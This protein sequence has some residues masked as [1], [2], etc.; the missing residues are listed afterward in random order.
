MVTHVIIKLTT[1]LNVQTTNNLFNFWSNIFGPQ[2]D[3]DIP[4]HVFTGSEARYNSNATYFEK[5]NEVIAS[6]CVLTVPIKITGIGGLAEVATDPLFRRKGLASKL[7]SVALQD[8][9]SND[10]E[11]LF[12][13]TGNPEA[14][15]IYHQLGWRKIT[16]ANV[17]VNIT[18]NISPEEYLTDRFT[19]HDKL[20]VE[21]AT[22]IARIPMIPL[23]INPHDWHVLDVNCGMFSTKYGI[24]NSCMGLYRRYSHIRAHGNGEWFTASTIDG[25]IVGISSAYML[26][27]NVD[28][29]DIDR[30]GDITYHGPGQLVGYPIVNLKNYRKSV[31]WYMHTLEEIIIFTLKDI[32][33]TAYR[34]DKLTGVWVEDEKICAFGVRMARWTT[35]HGFALNLNPDMTFFDGIIPCGIFEYGVTSIEEL[36]R[37]DLSIEKLASEVSN[38]C[39]QYFN[40]NVLNQNFA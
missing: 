11:A 29:I 22:P 7:C 39:N 35:M 4:K 10:G 8:F 2:T 26:D 37:I 31:S 25:K 21:L 15:R 16:G 40:K 34:R 19:K 36:S 20:I 5:Q 6:T 17:M 13:G 32:R 30:G 33:I 14:A 9:Q 27:K 3:P 12:L 1:P 23:L 24:Q 28:V 18:S 38:N